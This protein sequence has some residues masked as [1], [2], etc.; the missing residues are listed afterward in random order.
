MQFNPTHT[1][2]KQV[3]PTQPMGQPNL[4]PRLPKLFVFFHW[5]KFTSIGLQYTVHCEPPCYM[6]TLRIRSINV[7]VY[8]AII[9]AFNIQAIGVRLKRFA[10]RHAATH[11]MTDRQHC[12]L[13]STE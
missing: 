8:S 2:C 4:R 12:V 3:D 9:I 10:S 5:A 7:Y 13:R 11:R 1:C 6:I